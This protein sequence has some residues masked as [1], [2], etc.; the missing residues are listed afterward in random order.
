MSLCTGGH[1]VITHA[2]RRGRGGPPASGVLHRPLA[3]CSVPHAQPQLPCMFISCGTPAKSSAPLLL[4][5]S[6]QDGCVRDPRPPLPPLP[7]LPLP[8]PHGH[9]PKLAGRIAAA[10]AIER[11]QFRD[12]SARQRSCTPCSAA[13]SLPQRALRLAS[14]PQTFDGPI[15]GPARHPAAPA[16]RAT[17][18]GPLRN[19]D[20]DRLVLQ[21]LRKR[22]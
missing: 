21:Y 6:S 5:L 11:A 7:P 3:P 4:P 19:A 20:V 12:R 1:R 22:K 15:L 8:R 10:F 18:E 14:Q 9:A 13:K 2:A 17:M 16:A